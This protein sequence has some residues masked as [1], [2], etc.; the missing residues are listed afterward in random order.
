MD[1]E[2]IAAG[3]EVARVFVGYAGWGAGQLD[4]EVAAGAWFVVDAGPDDV[5]TDRARAALG[6]DPAPR[7]G[8]RR[9]WPSSNPSWN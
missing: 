7:R 8:P 1:P 3:I 9:P 6:R 2:A 5:F 4:D